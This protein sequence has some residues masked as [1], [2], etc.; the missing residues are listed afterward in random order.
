MIT[1]KMTAMM[2]KMISMGMMLVKFTPV[3]M[4]TFK[5][6]VFVRGAQI[7]IR[8]SDLSNKPSTTHQTK[9]SDTKEFVSLPKLL[10]KIFTLL[11]LPPLSSCAVNNTNTQF[12]THGSP[13]HLHCG[14]N[15]VLV[16][17]FRLS[18]IRVAH[19]FGSVLG[20]PIKRTFPHAYIVV[21]LEN[22]NFKFCHK[23]S[24]FWR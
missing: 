2:G 15:S 6:Q 1:K 9:F 12:K 20:P 17:F 4:V 19:L 10:F 14:M 8:S 21:V 24:L 22:S 13:S 18:I 5:S 23:F 7:W 16:F 11:S 3:R